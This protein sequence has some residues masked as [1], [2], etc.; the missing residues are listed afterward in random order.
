MANVLSSSIGFHIR[1]SKDAPGFGFGLGTNSAM[2]SQ[3]PWTQSSAFNQLASTSLFSTTTHRAQKRRHEPEDSE[4]YPQDE[5]MDRSPTPER[6][7]RAPPKRLRTAPSSDSTT[8][9]DNTSRARTTEDK[10]VDIG[11][12]LGTLPHYI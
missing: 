6:T 11:V 4:N 8:K 2:P 10:D 9:D 3:S 7:K 5:V 1:S 12:L